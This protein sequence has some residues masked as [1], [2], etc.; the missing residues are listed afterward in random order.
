MEIDEL[1][2]RIA[3]KAHAGQFRRDGKTQHIEH[4]KA[5]AAMFLG[6]RYAELR[7]ISLLHDVIEDGTDIDESALIASGIPVGTARIVSILTIHDEDYWEYLSAVKKNPSSK[8]VKTADML[9]SLTDDPAPAQ[10]KRYREGIMFL[11]M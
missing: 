2:L 3:Q 10:K 9:C 8:L 1:A 6:K 7:A 4:L 11:V 5:V